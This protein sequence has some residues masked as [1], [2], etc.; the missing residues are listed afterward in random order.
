[1]SLLGFLFESVLISLS[2]VM[3]PGPMTTVAVGKGSESPHAGA[4]VAVGHAIVELPLM[5]A[6]FY[7]IGRLLDFPYVQAI[8]ALVGG[9]FLL[10][11]GIGMVR[12]ARQDQADATAHPTPAVLAGILVSVGNPYFI[13]W[14]ATVGAALIVR[15]VRYGLLGF[16]S[17]A[18]L[19]SL[20]DL[21]WSWFLS[22]LSFKGSRFFGQRL[23][24]SI[25]VACGVLLLFFG[26]K[27]M[28]D[29]AM[30]LSAQ[31]IF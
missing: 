31:G 25:F 14:W 5:V 17:F 19:H 1:M 15:S 4:L 27:L 28:A 30:Q 7:G 22:A 8:I 29:G 12:G 21:L 2:G 9:A 11:M 10:V 18:L 20:C 13:V 3:A 23:Q 26:G 16:V 24:Q 6:V